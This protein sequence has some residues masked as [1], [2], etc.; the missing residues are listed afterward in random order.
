M[1]NWSLYRVLLDFVPADGDV[2]HS[3][4]SPAETKRIVTVLRRNRCLGA[5]L[6]LFDKDGVSGTLTFG[7]AHLKPCVSAQPDTVFR[8]A[9]ISKLVTGLGAMKL[10]EQGKIDLD[11][12]IGEYL[13]FTLRNAR[14]PERKITLRSLMTHT[15]GIR[16][17]EGYNS[18]IGRGAPL[19]EILDDAHVWEGTPG[20]WEYS[21][22]GAGIAGV[23]MEAATGVDFETLILLFGLFL[24]IAGITEIGIIGDFADWIVRVGGNN[25][26][27]LYSI[28]VW[29]SV[30]I[31]AFV[32]NI[33][34]VATMLPV[35]SVVTSELG[36]EPYLLYF[37]LLC[38]ATLGGNLTPVGASANITAMGLLRKHGYNA[39][40]KDY[41]RIGIPFTLTAV[42]AGYLFLWVFW[43]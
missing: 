38:G 2:N 3:D 18:G 27:L 34:Y 31:S 43:H 11:A 8:A 28:I 16:D 30:L 40:F 6:C 17:S 24:V 41:A 29:G 19:S 5:A 25:L 15:A 1:K 4:F 13:P 20:Q 10:K 23:V 26:F 32:D 9:S 36:V 21:N 33:P 39:T 12:D 22:L 14:K 35:L 7:K 37:G 42:M